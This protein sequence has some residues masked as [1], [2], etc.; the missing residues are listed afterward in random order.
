MMRYILSG[1]GRLISAI[2][3]AALATFGL[4]ACGNDSGDGMNDLGLKDNSQRPT[5]A[6][7]TPT[8][9][10]TKRSDSAPDY[11]GPYDAKFR[12]WVND[13]DDS[14]VAVT[15][16][17]EKVISENAFTLAGEGDSEDLLV[18]GAD[19]VSGLQA[20]SAVTV[21]GTVHK[22]F[23][24][25]GVEDDIHVDFEDDNVLQG[26]DRDPYVEAAQVDTTAPATTP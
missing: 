13:N 14:T 24:L 21:T 19:K 5:D 15:G 9:E 12:A 4:A 20:G 22:A 17:V 3:L 6:M 23:N 11:E 25:P 18:V 2:L 8:Q 26:F 16:N 7:Q 10:P 1:T